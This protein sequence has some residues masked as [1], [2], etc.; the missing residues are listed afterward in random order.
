M[1][2]TVAAAFVVL[3]V[4]SSPARAETEEEQ[5]LAIAGKLIDAIGG[6]DM[7][8]QLFDV[9]IAQM[10]PQIEAKNP[11]VSEKDLLIYKEEFAA[12]LQNEVQSMIVETAKIYARHLSIEEMQASIDFYQSP[13]GN[14]LLK[15]L[16]VIMGEAMELG[17]RLGGAIGENAANKAKTRMKERGVEL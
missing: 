6:A 5:R 10:W 7:Y 16:P 4:I 9:T 13:A 14:S 15:K 3:F 1:L 12:A 17:T 2:K 11:G 8:R